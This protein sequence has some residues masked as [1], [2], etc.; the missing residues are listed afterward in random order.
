MAPTSSQLA[1]AQ[2]WLDH[3]AST[4]ATSDAATSTAVWSAYRTIE[5]WANPDQTIDAAKNAVATILS[6]QRKDAGTAS[7]F[8]EYYLQLL[9]GSRPR[10][11]TGGGGAYVRNANPFDVYSRPVFA[12][13]D[14]LATGM[15][16]D[17]A[18]LEAKRRAEILSVTDAVLARRDAAIASISLSTATHYR[19]VIHP[20]LSQTGVCGLCIA[21]STAVYSVD[22]LMPIHSRCKCTVLPII[23]GADPEL[24]NQHD[25]EKLYAENPATK[26]QDLAATRYT[27]NTDGELGP[28]LTPAKGESTVPRSGQLAN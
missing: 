12:Y 1:D 3:Y 17:Q 8:V 13:R 4:T 28:V 2:A 19:R 15:Q 26:R 6:A 25:L 20:E 14:T 16:A 22:D 10:R 5:D 27:V 11:N 23:D 18:L 9:T 21:A 24:W 7:E